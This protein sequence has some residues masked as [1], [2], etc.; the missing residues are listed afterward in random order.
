M[1]IIIDLS[2]INAFFN[3]PS[4]V[5]MQR[6]LLL[7]GWI[8]VCFVFLWGALQMWIF[9]IQTKWGKT[10]KFILL[11]IDIPRNNEQTMKA[12]ENLFTYFGGAHGNKNLI[13]K[14]WIGE[15]QLDFSFEIVSIDGHTQFLIHSPEEFRNLVETAIYSQY[16]DAEITEVNDYTEGMP[17]KFPDDEYDIWGSEFIQANN[18]MYPI[19]TYK[20]FEHLIGETETQYKDTM[21]SLMDLCSSLR[22]GEQLWFQLLLTPIDFKWIEQGDREIS[23]I[24]K[25]KVADDNIVDKA[26]KI[27]LQ[28]LS[29]ASETV[30]SMWGDIE[31][32]EKEED[33]V[34]K[35]MNLKPKEKKQIEAIQE[36][37]SQQG[38]ETKI[39]F[40]Y[41][42][43]K[44]VMN[45]PKVVNGF[46]GFMKQFVDLDLN[47]FKPDLD[48][49]ITST[50]YLLKDYR[51]NRRKNNI[52]KGYKNRSTA[53]GR[54][55]GLL[56][57]EEL[58]TL[59]HFPVEHVVKAPL[60]QKTPGK[61]GKPPMYLPVSEKVVSEDIFETHAK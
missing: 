51:L 42:A 11:A 46:V 31:D 28:W 1:D 19:K 20:H 6:L 49:T 33:D 36:K 15:F 14:Y 26:I 22:K 38:F 4:Y 44:D 56:N 32:K 48:M 30:Y 53:I 12:V 34:L 41:L 58:A 10:Q 61:K 25:E 3:Q 9:Y 8:P 45:K 52:I 16:P 50:A 21:A 17:D 27:F 13:E 55:Q 23:K 40:I 2:S 7:F 24:L 60:I 43:K 35:M 5:I 54:N 57:I 59:W 18:P 39:R 29:D 37:I 47:N